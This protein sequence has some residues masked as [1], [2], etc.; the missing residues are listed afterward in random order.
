[1][2]DAV[3]LAVQPLGPPPWPTLDPFLFCVHH[4]DAYPEGDDRMAPKASLAGRNMGS[5]FSGKDGWS[6]YH[7][8]SVP[9]FPRHPHRGFETLTL[10]RRGFIDH[11][12]SLGATARFGEG[13]AQWMTAGKGIVHA[14]MFPLVRRDAPNPG[15]LFQLWINLPKQ[16]KMVDPYFT[17]FWRHMIPRHR[18]VDDAG[19]VIEVV[20]VAG[21]L[22]E[23]N[24]PPP[25]PSSWAARDEAHVAVWTLKLQPGARW[26][27]PAAQPKLN[28]VLYVFNGP[29]AQ[30]GGRKVEGKVA[31][32][33]KSDAAVE[34]V[35]GPQTT[36]LLMLQGRPIGEP[37]A[38]HGPFVMNTRSELQQAYDDYRR[39]QFGGW[40]W[41]ADAPVHERVAGRFAIHADGRREEPAS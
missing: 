18:F 8:Q 30:I 7:G 6:M 39:T 33:L 26:T 37:V 21:D 17:M 1:M 22:D 36:E 16:S 27:L 25:P 38:Q 24:A 35:A 28:R 19:K 23:R 31:V 5:D 34:L 11:S 32:Q 14:E 12:D 9:G 10:A 20:T 3:V 13:D 29:S 15:E 41:K 40:P 4:D 2:N